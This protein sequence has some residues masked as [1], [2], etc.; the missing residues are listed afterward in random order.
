MFSSAPLFS[1]K[2]SRAILARDY[3]PAREVRVRVRTLSGIVYPVETSL[4]FRVI[5]LKR[6]LANLGVHFCVVQAACASR[7][8][9]SLY[10]QQVMFW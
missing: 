7:A 5:D 1:V 9:M 8:L 6:R 4:D 10:L 3:L 2:G